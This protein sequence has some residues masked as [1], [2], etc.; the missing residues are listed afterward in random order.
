MPICSEPSAAVLK[1]VLLNAF[2]PSTAGCSVKRLRLPP[3]AM[4]S[5]ST[6]LSEMFRMYLAQAM[7]LRKED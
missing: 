6:G 1:A 3:P 7:K 2:M 4:M 5:H